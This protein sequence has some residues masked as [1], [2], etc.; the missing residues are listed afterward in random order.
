M[1]EEHENP[2]AAGSRAGRGK[3]I[4][5]NRRSSP[6]EKRRAGNLG[7]KDRGRSWPKRY[8]NRRHPVMLGGAK[9]SDFSVGG[10]SSIIQRFFASLRM[11]MDS[12]VQSFNVLAMKSALHKMSR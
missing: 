6:S 5:S 8:T 1:H 9:D 2:P 4:Q 11:T 7:A 3:T 10:S 12:S